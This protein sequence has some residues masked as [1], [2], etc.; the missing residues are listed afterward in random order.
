MGST[1]LGSFSAT[2][3]NGPGFPP[4]TPNTAGQSY[5]VTSGLRDSSAIQGNAVESLLAA[6]GFGSAAAA[7]SGPNWHDPR[8]FDQPA[9][10][11]HYHGARSGEL[12]ADVLT[13][14]KI[15]TISS[16][17]QA[18]IRVARE[19]IYPP[20]YSTA[21]IQPGTAAVTRRHATRRSSTSTPTAFATRPGRCGLQCHPIRGKPTVTRSV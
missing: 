1:Q 15:V 3:G 18:Q 19:F 5:D 21:T 10:P 11:T 14:P 7:G 16:S 4:G 17:Q 13:S 8:H 6:S 20:T 2:G 9:V 12:S